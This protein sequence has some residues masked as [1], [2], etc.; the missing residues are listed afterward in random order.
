MRLDSS[1]QRA[2]QTDVVQMIPN[3]YFSAAS[4]EIR[5]MYIAGYF[6]GA[7][8]LSQSVAEGLSRFL[9]ERNRIRRYPKKDHLKRVDRLILEKIISLDT[10]NAF[11]KIEE[12]R[13]DF[14]HMNENITANR[15][16]LEAKAKLNVDRLFR[17]EKEIFDY[18]INKGVL[19]PVSSQ[20]WDISADG[21][22]EAFLRSF[23]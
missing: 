6:I 20:Y 16:D 18:R 15:S 12:R 14:H 11:Y 4:A 19:V 13:N 5:E 10:K 7:I 9:C 21:T 17:I 8:T 3:H 22:T 1:V 23:P 2:E